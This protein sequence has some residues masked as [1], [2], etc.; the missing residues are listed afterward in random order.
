VSIVV[1]ELEPRALEVIVSED[2]ISVFLSDGR[3]ISVPLAWS[4]RLFNADHEQRQNYRLIGDGLGIRWPDLD[5]DISIEGMLR[6]GPAKRP[7]SSHA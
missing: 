5:E 3:R 7:A 2:E 6:G 1:K 4:W